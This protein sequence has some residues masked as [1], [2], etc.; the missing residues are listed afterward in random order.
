MAEAIFGQINPGGKLTISFPRHSGQVPVYYN[1]LPGWH[2][3]KYVDL[4]ETP[5]FS[6]GEGLSYTTF[7][8]T[9]LR[10]DRDTLCVSVTLQ[11]T[12]SRAGSET[13]QVYLRDLVS[14]VMTPLKRLVAFQKVSL[15]A[16]ESRELVF[17]LKRDDFSLVRA[18]ETRVVEPGTFALF[19]GG[20][21]RD[22]DLLREE[23][24]LE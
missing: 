11:N 14:S 10:V 21:S 8:Y 4:P 7:A 22:C 23:L 24:T 2:G 13:A 1:A 20:S 12:G 15:D 3:E 5:L 19:V 9:N 6:F 17:S 16:G 18:D